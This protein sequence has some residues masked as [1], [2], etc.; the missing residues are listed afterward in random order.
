MTFGPFDDYDPDRDVFD[1]APLA[2]RVRGAPPGAVC[3]VFVAPRR[4]GKT[5]TLKALAHHIGPRARF[6]DTRGAAF[7]EP[8]DLAAGDTVLV[9]EPGYTLRARGGAFVAGCRAL[10]ARGVRVVVAA[11]PAEYED[12][13]A[14]CQGGHGDIAGA[15]LHAPRLTPEGAAKLAARGADGA[16]LLARV[17]EAWRGTPFLLELC[18]YAI[19][20]DPSLVDADAVGRRAISLAESEYDYM[21]FAWCQGLSAAQRDV[22]RAC[23]RGAPVADA[24]A[25]DL[26]E[27]AGVLTKDASNRVRVADP[28]LAAHLAPLRIH[29]VS[30]VHVGPKSYEA[31]DIK[32]ADPAPPDAMGP[33]FIRD[34]Y[35]E[36]LQHLRAEGTAPHVLVCSGDCVEYASSADQ[37]ADFAAWLARAEAELAPHAAVPA[38]QRTLLVGGNHDVDWNLAARGDRSRHAAF[39]ATV[40]ARPH[41]GLHHDPAHRAVAEVSFPEAGVSFALLGSA[42][43]GGT[44]TRDPFREALLH[45]LDAAAPH[46]PAGDVALQK[47]VGDLRARLDGDPLVELRGVLDQLC[48]ADADGKRR[49][50]IEGEHWKV[51][52]IDPGLVDDRDL[53]RLRGH[54]W[55]HPVRIAV[56]HH[57]VSPLP[58]TEVARFGGLVNAGA[59]KEALLEKGFQLV[60]HG[61]VH[62]GWFVREEAWMTDGTTRTLAVAAAPTLGSRETAKDQ[63]FNEVE[64]ARDYDDAGRAHYR[65]VVRRCVRD[66]ATWR[67]DG[68][69]MGLGPISV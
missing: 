39:A 6:V 15:V 16:A 21:R 18:L 5:W 41:P 69:E 2:R 66:N 49:A 22:V 23:L 19:E 57:P 11:T 48:A 50:A 51:M 54:A 13:S 9:D 30:D 34:R 7:S 31:T 52:R 12:L 24:A 63:G 64:V 38:S 42:E 58:D 26:L 3:W 65:V 28:I 67:T 47:R 32:S 56:L 68:V 40:G 53:A 36:H 27:R 33:R 45:A 46:V 59:V 29:H 14:C 17:P 20:L 25:R 4:G 1:R 55:P 62:R 61:H 35:V 60:L 8:T 43:Y 10:Q 44:V 37:Y